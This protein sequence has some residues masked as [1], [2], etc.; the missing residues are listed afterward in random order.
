MSVR[1]A[2]PSSPI[3]ALKQSLAE[4][5]RRDLPAEAFLSEW[6]RS[7]RRLVR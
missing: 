7:P 1:A 6:L 3:A 4:L 5:V 2:P